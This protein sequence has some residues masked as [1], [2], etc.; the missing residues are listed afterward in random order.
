MFRLSQW[1]SSTLQAPWPAK[2]KAVTGVTLILLSF[3]VASTEGETELL[4]PLRIRDM[5]PFNILRLDML[6]AHAGALVIKADVSR[7]A[8]I[9]AAMDRIRKKFGRPFRS[10][11]AAPPWS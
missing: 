6:P 4:G 1:I 8:E 9:T 11:P 10:S 5:T 2:Q 3:T 7:V